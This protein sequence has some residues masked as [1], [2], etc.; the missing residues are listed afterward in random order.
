VIDPAHA[1]GQPIVSDAAVPMRTLSDAVS[2]EGSV[3]VVARLFRVDPR[4]VRA[5]L[6]F[7]QRIA[8]RLAA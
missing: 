4:S 5:A 7:E 2:A 8:E 6:R 3:S 1:F